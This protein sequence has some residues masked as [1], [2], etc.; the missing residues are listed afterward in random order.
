MPERIASN[1]PDGISW[2]RI[3]GLVVISVMLLSA[4]VFAPVRSSDGEWSVADYGEVAP[5]EVWV[6]VALLHSYRERIE[7]QPVAVAGGE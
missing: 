1:A 7:W 3:A 2:L 6:L 5:I 4:I